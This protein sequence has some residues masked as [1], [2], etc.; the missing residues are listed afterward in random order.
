VCG[1]DARWGAGTF[2]AFPTPSER[3]CW[4]VNDDGSVQSKGQFLASVKAPNAQEQ[5]VSPEMLQVHV[6]GDVAI[7]TGVLRVK[8][9]SKGRV[10]VRREGFVD[11]WLLKGATWVCIATD[12]TP[13]TY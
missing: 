10:Y 2:S 6:H 3:R 7:A 1:V 8:G 4:L 9:V 5:Q 12:A 11:T 13:I